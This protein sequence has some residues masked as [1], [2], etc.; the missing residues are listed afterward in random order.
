MVINSNPCIAYLMKDNTL[1]LQVLTMAHVYGHNDFFRNNRLFKAGTRA[2]HTVELFKNHAGRVRSYI[3]D[4]SIGYARVEK[5][6][7][8][9]HA[10]RYQCA[11]TIG[12]KKLN[13]EDQVK[14]L[15]EA[16]RKS[17]SDFPLLEEPRCKA[18]VEPDLRRVPLQPEEDLLRFVADYGRLEKW[19]R[20]LL[21][22]VREETLYF[23]PQIETKIMNEGWASYWHYAILKRIDL[24]QQMHIEF[25]RR[26]NQVVK[27]HE[28]G[29]NPYYLGFKMFEDI[30]AKNPGNPEKIFEVREI[31]R[32]SSF[33]RR[34]L[35][36]ELCNEMHL[37]EF[38]KDGNEYVVS[39]VADEDGW[40]KIRDTI[41]NN[42]G[43][44]GIPMI[45]V[46]DFIQKENTLLLEHVHDGRDLELN[47]ANETL[48]HMVD[49]W[50]G[51]IVLNT[52][53]DGKK[54]SVI[55]DEQ[56][57]IVLVNT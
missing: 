19:E 35:T 28:G 41:A 26:H 1:L 43:M 12:E 36:K 48:R 20:D 11:R 45:R 49:L 56:K 46:E 25:L 57:K 21:D 52:F 14:R 50:E 15:Q 16:N 34:Y 4:P 5:M 40:M 2:E 13:A 6:L 33:L 42:A 24:P 44:G 17:E 10:L 29:I 23:V 39:E 31:E 53:V 30:F 55:C 9:A 27:N 32:D 54:K 7:N 38:E 51:R 47:Y 8:A 22:I 37:Y 3:S 18:Y